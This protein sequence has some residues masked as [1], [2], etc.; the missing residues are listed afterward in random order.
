MVAI[1]RN[2]VDNCSMK[3]KHFAIA[4]IAGVIILKVWSV[5]YG[6]ADKALWTNQFAV[7]GIENPEGW[8]WSVLNPIQFGQFGYRLWCF[9]VD[10]FMLA[11]QLKIQRIPKF[12]L[13]LAH[14]LST[15]HYV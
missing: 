4:I 2:G 13:A 7:N 10:M 5:L 3:V 1:S 6:T 12:Y 8:L 11:L 14:V 15:Y 9:N